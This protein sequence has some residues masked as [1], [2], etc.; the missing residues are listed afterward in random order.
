MALGPFPV[1]LALATL[2]G[3]TRQPPEHNL[4]DAGGDGQPPS[5]EL[6]AR[7][8]VARSADGSYNDL[9]R[10]ALG[11]AGTRFGRNVPPRLLP[12]GAGVPTAVTEPADSESRAA[13]PAGLCARAH[14]E[15][16][17]RRLAAVRDPRLVQPWHGNRPAISGATPA[18]RHLGGRPDT[19]AAH[20]AR[21]TAAGDLP[22]TFV[23]HRNALVGRIAALRQLPA[24]PRRHPAARFGAGRLAIGAPGWSTSTLR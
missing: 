14:A 13:R 11:M 19:G 16:V 24:V 1:P 10:P 20:Q 18:G 3:V 7:C 2:I 6:P 23:K 22:G 17:G 12:T 9:T 21:P 4:Y 5:S 8:L 15:C